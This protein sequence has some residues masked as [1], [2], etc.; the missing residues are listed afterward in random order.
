M[1]IDS[2]GGKILESGLLSDVRVSADVNG[3]QLVIT[4]PAKS[5]GLIE[6]LVKELDRLCPTPRRRS[7]CS[8]SST[9]DATTLQTMLS[10]LLGQTAQ[11]GAQGMGGAGGLFGQGNINPFLQPSLQS[12]AS[13]GE[14]SLVPI[15]FGV[16]K[17]SNSIIASGSDGDLGV[18]E[19]VL[20]RLDEDTLHKH[21]TTVY[22]LANAPATNVATALNT[23]LTARIN[24]YTTQMN[25]SPENPEVRYAQQVVVT[26]ETI[27]NSI[28]VSA[29]PSL[30]EELK[31]VIEALDRRPPMIKIDVMIAEVTLT[32]NFEFGTEFGVQ[33]SLLYSRTRTT[34]TGQTGFNFNGPNAT[35][36]N[37]TGL[38]SLVGAGVP[39]NLTSQGLTSFNLGRQSA[40]GY[41]GLVLSASNDAI[42]VLLRALQEK[43]RV[44]ILSRPQITTLDSQPA[45]IQVGALVS[46][47]GGSTVGTGGTTTSSVTDVPTGVILGVTPRVTPDGLVVMEI[48]AQKSK[49]NPVEGVEI[50]SSVPDV[51]SVKALNIDITKATTVI[52]AR[53]G[54][55]V[56]FAGLIET[57]K[58]RTTR[59]IPY[60]SELPLLG[61]LFRFTSNADTRKELLIVMTPHVVRDDDEVDA[62]RIAESERMSWCL[63]DVAEI[64][65]NVGFSGRPGEWCDSV[66]PGGRCQSMPLVFPD[67]NPSGLEPVP[68]PASAGM[69]EPAPLSAPVTDPPQARNFRSQRPLPAMANGAQ[70]NTTGFADTRQGAAGAYPR[71]A[72]GLFRSGVEWAGGT[73]RLPRPEQPPARSCI[74]PTACGRRR[75]AGHDALDD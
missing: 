72:G 33:D 51:P 14:S 56:V 15:R 20:L 38:G 70:G 4:G 63:A 68:T 74:T 13:M 8:R 69:P 42:S 48:D 46:R 2:E 17:R 49:L 35:T 7:R 28:I 30:F 10:S 19:A 43:G 16:D 45:N 12:A 64:Y 71:C 52:S 47:Y 44:Q 27:S 39:G 9:A 55:T 5:M 62:I 60:L 1:T 34:A 75:R 61:P 40:L 53:S 11:T 18:V 57:E 21:K 41:G 6:A 58:D 32:D 26:P 23:W 73:G 50:P 22:W 25:L 36:S 54:Q 67:E 31:K 66:R 65:G 37:L 29:V 24:Q 3:N 59:G